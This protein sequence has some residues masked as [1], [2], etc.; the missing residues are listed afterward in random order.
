MSSRIHRRSL[1]RSAAAAAAA[2]YG[3]G[4]SWSSETEKSLPTDDLLASD[5]DKYW[6]R[7][8]EDQ[9]YLPEWRSFLNNGSLGIAPRP[10]LK[11]VAEYLERSAGL[12]V[13]EYPRWGYE[14][15]DEHRT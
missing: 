13:D 12:M 6:L 1:F 3:V 15:L 2:L 7:I 9:F 14:T 8:R 10:V 5:P 11:A 4:P